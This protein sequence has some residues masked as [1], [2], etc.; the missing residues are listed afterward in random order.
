MRLPH[1]ST[2]DVANAGVSQVQFRLTARLGVG[3]QDGCLLPG[4]TGMQ[5]ETCDPNP[6]D[7]SH[8]EPEP[9][10]FH[11]SRLTKH[12]AILRVAY[13]VKPGPVSAQPLSMRRCFSAA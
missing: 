6:G 7:G 3:L 9:C 10:A 1:S 2:E 5:E 8:L 12:K 4:S 13:V 11:D